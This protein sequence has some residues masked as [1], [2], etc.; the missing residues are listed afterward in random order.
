MDL[1]F[2]LI[3][4]EEARQKSV[5]RL[6]PSENY[7]S[8]AVSLAMSSCFGNK[9]SEGYAGKR[10]YQGVESVDELENLAIER[11]KKLFGVLYANVFGFWGTFD[12]WFPKNHF[13]RQIF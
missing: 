5:L 6:I 11:A 9:Y 4:K 13:F 2:E 12:T 8:K 10:Y 1:V 3:Q 7:V